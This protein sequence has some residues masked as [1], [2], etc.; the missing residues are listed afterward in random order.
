[1]PGYH[2]TINSPKFPQY[3]EKKKKEINWDYIT[4]SQASGFSPAQTAQGI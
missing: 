3:S 2:I 4:T 1:M